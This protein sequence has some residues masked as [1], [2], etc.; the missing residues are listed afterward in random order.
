MRIRGL[1]AKGMAEARSTGESRS[2]LRSAARRIGVIFLGVTLLAGPASGVAAA[3]TPVTGTTRVIVTSSGAGARSPPSSTSTSRRS[4]SCRSL[5]APSP[6][7]LRASSRRCSG[8]P[9][10]SCRPTSPSPVAAAPMLSGAGPH[11]GRSLP[12]VH[13]RD[14]PRHLRHQPG[15]ASTSPSSIPASTQL[16]DFAGRLVGGVDLSG[17]GNAF[18]DSYGHGT[19]VAGLIAGNGASSGGPVPRVRRP[20]AGLV[21][22]KVADR[23]GATDVAGLITGIAWAVANQHLL[24]ISVLNISLGALPVQST[25]INPLDRA[26]E[27]AWHSGITVVASAGNGGPFNGTV[28]SPGDDPLV[29]TVGAVDDSGTAAP[30]RRHH[31]RLQR[32]RTHQRRRLDQARPGGVGP[33]G[34]Q[35]PGTRD[36]RSTP[37]YPSA[38]IG[39]ANFVGSGTSFSA[40]IT[41]GAAALV[42]QQ[43][44]GPGGPARHAARRLGASPDA[45][46]AKLLG[47]TTAGPVGNPFVDGH[48][49]LNAAAAASK[50]LSL[51]Q[52]APVVPVA[53]GSTVS[54]AAH[55]GVEL[56]EPGQLE[57][58]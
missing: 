37:T 16:P 26:V 48:G 29:V 8:P 15:T 4:A 31:G 21:S 33:F 19:F 35:P 56:L 14:R 25:A 34:R 58:R 7:S 17:E 32:R 38:R 46:K 2:R 44:Q 41:S 42:V 30:G 52:S 12:P 24:N 11:P 9:A 6:M 51:N 20:G 5:A 47:S 50:Q 57:R 55:V 49:Q 3:D 53:Y 22:I 27:L 23:T 36:R 54:L 45:V 1:T 43:A 39:T 40:A 28:L 10:S 18:L 13:G